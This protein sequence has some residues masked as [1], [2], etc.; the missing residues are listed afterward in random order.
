MIT[1]FDPLTAT[2]CLT[3]ISTSIKSNRGMWRKLY[4]YLSSQYSQSMIE[5]MK[6][7]VDF[8][9]VEGTGE[10]GQLPGE[11]PPN[12]KPIKSLRWEGDDVLAKYSSLLILSRVFP[13]SY[14]SF[15]VNNLGVLPNFTV[16][17][18]VHS[19]SSISKEVIS[20]SSSSNMDPYTTLHRAYEHLEKYLQ[21]STSDVYYN[22]SS[23]PIPIEEGDNN[24]FIENYGHLKKEIPYIDDM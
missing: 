5:S 9:H 22:L 14:K 10:E 8:I 2:K 1:R 3:H 11:D 16:D 7:P 20:N 18:Y 13:L 19:I 12:M 24:Y 23:M 6:I 21:N 4:N 17:D 15:F